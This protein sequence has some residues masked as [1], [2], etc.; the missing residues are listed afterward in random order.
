MS[1]RFA[2]ILFVGLVFFVLAGRAPAREVMSLDG[3]WN[4]ATDPDS[5]GETEK[6]YQP[7]TKLPPMPLPGYAPGANGTI[8]VPGIWDNQGY[9]AETDRVRHNFTGKGWYKRQIE[10]PA[11]WAGQHVFLLITGS[12]RYAKAWV[13]DQF[14]GEH[15]GH[16]SPAEYDVTKYVT[17]GRLATITIQVDSKQRWEIDAMY[18]CSFLADDIDTPWGGIWGHV[19]LEARSDVWLSDLYLRP[20]VPH[21]SCAASAILKGK[22][23]LADGAKLEVF[24]KSGRRAGEATIKT[25]PDAVTGQPVEV[26][27]SL[28]NAELWTPDNPTLYTAGAQCLERGQ[29][30]RFGRESFWDAAVYDRWLPFALERQADHAPR[31]WR[32]P[33]LSERNGHVLGIR[34]CIF[35]GCARSNRTASITSATTARSCRRS[36]TTHAMK[37]GSSPRRSFASATLLGCRVGPGMEESRAIGHESRSGDGHLPARMGGRDQAQSQPSVDHLLGDG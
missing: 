9:G 33:H 25:D 12:S 27:V 21:S 30:R 24:D 34:T 29:S 17:P 19:V 22:A 8:Q 31:L 11:S 37:R 28:P 14:L 4:F 35:P 26:K 20:D 23:D 5:R 10:I 1:C 16:L 2:R 13:D 36:I 6:W 3:V 15:I 7:N 18:G 32:R